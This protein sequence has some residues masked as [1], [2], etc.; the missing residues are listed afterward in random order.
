[1]PE[2]MSP[3]GQRAHVGDEPYLPAPTAPRESTRTDG[4]RQSAEKSARAPFHLP[5]ALRTA[6]RWL[7]VLPL[8]GIGLAFLVSGLLPIL[9][10]GLALLL[11]G[12]APLLV[13]GLGILATEAVGLPKD[14]LVRGGPSPS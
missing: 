9:I 3:H 13:V 11:L 14:G 1:M 6:L 2:L 5:S 8:V 4:P 7:I 12:L 10:V